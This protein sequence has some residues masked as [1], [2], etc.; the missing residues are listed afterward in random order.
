MKEGRKEG[1]QLLCAKITHRTRIHWIEDW[2]EMGEFQVIRRVWCE[3][4]KLC[5]SRSASPKNRSQPLGY[6]SG[7]EG[8]DLLVKQLLEL[9]AADIILVH[10]NVISKSRRYSK[11]GHLQSNSKNSG[12]RGGATG[13]SSGSCCSCLES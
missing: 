5:S 7:A 3:I 10:Y 11:E 9:L 8:H 6:R 1:I 13:S 2:C 12:S 4:Q